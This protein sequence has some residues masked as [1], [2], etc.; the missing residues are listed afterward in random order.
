MGGVRLVERMLARLRY[1]AVAVSVLVLAT[2]FGVNSRATAQGPTIR[3][4]LVHVLAGQ[5]LAGGEAS[6][7]ANDASRITLTGKGTFV[8]GDRF[9]VTGGGTWTLSNAKGDT[10]DSGTYT[11]TE[12]L[13]W[14]GA[15]GTPG[16]GLVDRIGK[17]P[18]KRAGVAVLQVRYSNGSGGM[19]VV[20]CHGDVSPDTIFEGI[21]ASMGFVQFWNR[22]APVGGVDANRTVFHVVP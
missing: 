13:S 19:L 8:P 6:A 1:A 14:D 18:D 21:I 2:I 16:V 20:S 17:D 22:E 9:A 12:L 15:P 5:L 11:V 4:D 10:T 7:K 3:W